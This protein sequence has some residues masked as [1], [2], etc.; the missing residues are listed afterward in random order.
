GA[1]APEVD[2][3]GVDA[4]LLGQ[5]LASGDDVVD[6]AVKDLDVARAAAPA[7]ASRVHHHQAGL[8][9]L[10]GRLIVFGGEFLPGDGGDAVAEPAGEPNDGG[11]LFGRIGDAEVGVHFAQ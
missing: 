10:P 1:V 4:R 8:T 2:P 6:F 5:P 11:S 7:T 3:I 9:V